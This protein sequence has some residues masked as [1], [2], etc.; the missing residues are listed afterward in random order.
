MNKIK[1]SQWLILIPIFIFV[2]SFLTL[3]LIVGF[4]TLIFYISILTLLL[5]I[6][7]LTYTFEENLWEYGENQIEED[8]ELLQL[9]KDHSVIMW[10]F[11]NAVGIAFLIDGMPNIAEKPLSAILGLILLIVGNLI[12]D[13]AY[14]PRYIMLVRKRKIELDLEKKKLK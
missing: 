2:T 1:F 5:V 12:Y 11:V 7:I 10:A 6:Y 4:N 14:Y 3:L 8:K 9:E 13:F